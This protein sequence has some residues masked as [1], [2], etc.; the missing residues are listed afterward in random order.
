MNDLIYEINKETKTIKCT[1]QN[2]KRDFMRIT[3][4][5][6]SQHSERLRY[7]Y[8]FIA[9]YHSEAAIKDEYTGK[10]V[11]SDHDIFNEEYGMDIA[12]T[13]AIIKRENAFQSTLESIFN[14][15]DLLMEINTS[16]DRDRILDK[17][18]ENMCDLLDGEMSL[19][20][21]RGYDKN[22][23]YNISDNIDLNKDYTPHYC[24]LCNKE[25]LNYKDDVEYLKNEDMWQSV[26]LCGGKIEIC[27]V[28]MD[29]IKKLSN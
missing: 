4:K 27:Q 2:C 5:I 8:R 29:A 14:D 21:I 17:H 16:I 28:C 7:F 22:D 10:S 20:K 25:F 12:R 9:A 6:L 11:C 1:V 13:K 19:S 26:D 15:I 23:E 3:D 24:S 18:L